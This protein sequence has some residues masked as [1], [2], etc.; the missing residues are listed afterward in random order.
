MK[1]FL[2]VLNPEQ[3]AAVSTVDGAVLIIAGAG[4]GKTRTLVSRLAYL[5]EEARIAPRNLL[6]LTFTVKAADEMRERAQALCTSGIDLAPV[7]VGTFHSLCFDILKQHGD[8][9]GL[10]DEISI[11]SPPA[12]QRLIAELAG[13]FFN[14]G[15][16]PAA[17]TLCRELALEKSTSQPTNKLSP[18]C[19]A[20]QSELTRRSLLD[21]DDLILK[22]VELLQ[23]RPAVAGALRDRFSHVS[24][25]EYQDVS[26]AQYLLLR[27]LCGRHPNLCAVGDADQAIYAFRGAQVKNFLNF[28]I[29]F[30]GTTVCYLTDN[31]RSSATIIDAAQHVIQNNK[32]RI[33]KQLRPARPEG[34][35]IHVVEL[36]DEYMEADWIASEIASLL[37][38]IGFESMCSGDDSVRSFSD[39]AILYRLR[40]QSR[41]LLKALNRRGIPVAEHAGNWLFEN[42]QVQILLDLLEI[43]VNPANDGAVADLLR[44]GHF[45]P[46]ERS[47]ERLIAEA[48]RQGVPLV[49]LCRNPETVPGLQQRACERIRILGALIE[50]IQ[51]R[52]PSMPLYQLINW[53][54]DSVFA[55]S[56]EP[57][58]D[59]LAFATAALPFSRE[60]AAGSAGAFLKKVYLMREGESLAPEQ[61][62]V[63]LMTAHGAKGLEFPVVFISGAEQNL[64]PCHLDPQ[65]EHDDAQ[66]EEERRLFYVAMTRARDRLYIT[67]ARS[68]YVFGQSLPGAPSR[69]SA[70]IPEDC[71]RRVAVPSGAKAKQKPVQQPSLFDF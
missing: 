26:R 21:F 7:T 67:S 70:E 19:R 47:A 13:S 20:Y 11:I 43:L 5:V 38:G 69:F 45:C 50:D 52:S 60:G 49:Q 57:D 2:R 24:V 32:I 66:V 27:L 59:M 36:D 22:T 34:A 10:P 16:A 54:W 4:T 17:R 61:E 9:I 40:Q 23:A 39:I 18:F 25:D 48:V 64:F 63:R 12:Q 29:D 15:P 46:G 33:E 56:L 55:A 14:D 41:T 8:L 68:R 51:A 58:D 42:R 37:G 35:K 71:L 65:E 6:A 28:Q 1:D 44:S 62:C 3:R 31:Y 53:L 30:P